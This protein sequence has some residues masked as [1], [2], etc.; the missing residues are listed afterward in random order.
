[1]LFS[2]H[3][4]QLERAKSRAQKQ[5]DRSLSVGRFAAC[6]AILAGFLFLLFSPEKITL[7]WA[8]LVGT[9]ALLTSALALLSCVSFAKSRLERCLLLTIELEKL[10]RTHA[11]LEA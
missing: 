7:R 6:A 3:I 2:P 4:L 11:A 1:M 8:L 10:L 9:V 5:S